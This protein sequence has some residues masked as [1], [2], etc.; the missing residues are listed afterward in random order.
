[1]EDDD[2]E[3]V[4]PAAAPPMTDVDT[5]HILS[6]RQEFVYPAAPPPKKDVDISS[7]RQV[8][9]SPTQLESLYDAAYSGDLP[10]LKMEF[11]NVV[12]STEVE[13]FYLA[14]DASSSRTGFTLLHV[15]ASR[16]HYDVAVW[17]K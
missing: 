10:R 17:C 4:Y 11:K 3:F 6:P 1:M 14:N 8:Q 7:P 16:G 15:A 13:P 12:E 2:E 9:P 5:E